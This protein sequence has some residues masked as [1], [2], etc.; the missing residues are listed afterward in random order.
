MKDKH[1]SIDDEPALGGGR[2]E[3]DP[4]E[5]RAAGVDR[6]PDELEALRDSVG[7]EPALPKHHDPDQWTRWLS[8]KQSQCTAAGN[9]GVTLLAAL[10]G[11]PFAIVGA[12][13]AGHRGFGPVVYVIV[14]GPVVEELLKQSG[15]TYVL[16]KKP[17]RIFSTWQFVFSAVLSGLAFAAIENLVYI[18]RFAAAANIKDVGRL[19]FYRWTVCTALHVTC[20]VIASLGLIRVWKR[21]LRD[22]RPADLAAAVPFFAAAMIAHGLYNLVATYF[23]PEF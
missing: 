4:A 10:L 18:H 20:A 11:G 14:F 19:A 13:V 8:R 15:M 1:F 9:L 17:Y 16:E 5:Q 3:P 21:Q 22:G 23:G 2:F 12:L 7:S 6:P